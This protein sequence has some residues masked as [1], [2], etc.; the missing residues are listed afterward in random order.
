MFL[1][2]SPLLFRAV[3][4][5]VKPFIDP[6]TRTKVFFV[7]KHEAAD[8]FADNFDPKVRSVTHPHTES[9]TEVIV[10]VK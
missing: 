6:V 2:R 9:D 1:Y 8:I 5:I 4:A 10:V 7:N 3:W